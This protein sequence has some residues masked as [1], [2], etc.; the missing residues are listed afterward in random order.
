MET[1]VDTGLPLSIARMYLGWHGE[2][3]LEPLNG[4]TACPLLREDGTVVLSEGY[5]PSSGMWCEGA[6]ATPDLAAQPSLDDAKA[7]L[8]ENGGAKVFHG[9]GGM[10]P[11]R[12]A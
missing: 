2:L 8:R 5:D 9:S 7:S 11:L 1:E 10:I 12:A 4:I 3:Q 6:A